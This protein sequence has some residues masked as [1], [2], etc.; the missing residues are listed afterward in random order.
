MY[1]SSKG[2]RLWLIETIELFI[3]TVLENT[4]AD[5]EIVNNY[6]KFGLNVRIIYLQ[7][8]EIVIYLSM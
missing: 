3:T 4:K 7:E 1:V 2:I 6:F 8:N 5:D